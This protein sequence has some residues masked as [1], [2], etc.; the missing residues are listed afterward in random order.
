MRRIKL[1]SLKACIG[2]V[3]P[4]TGRALGQAGFT[5]SLVPKIFSAEHLVSALGRR[6]GKKATGKRILFPRSVIASSDPIHQLQKYGA[7]VDAVPLY[8]VI[9]AR[10]QSKILASLKKGDIKYIVF[11]SPSS[12]AAFEVALKKN[13]GI[14]KHSFSAVCI[15]PS[16][17][18]AA[19]TLASRC[20]TKI[21]T[22]KSATRKDIAGL[23]RRLP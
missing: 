16:T 12:V 22:A 15:G 10:L 8:T 9:P 5:I 4:E 19:R 2:A 18:Y 17:A 11:T 20:F 3:G 6:L 1:S 13:R 23:L 7:K 21:Y 14:K